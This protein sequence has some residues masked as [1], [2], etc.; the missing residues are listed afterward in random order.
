MPPMALRSTSVG[1]CTAHRLKPALRGLEGC[2]DRL[3]FG[4]EFTKLVSNSPA[5]DQLVVALGLFQWLYGHQTAEERQG[6]TSL[7]RNNLGF[8]RADA[9]LAGR[10]YHHALCVEKKISRVELQELIDLLLKYTGQLYDNCDEIGA[11]LGAYLKHDVTLLGDDGMSSEEDGSFVVP[12]HESDSESEPPPSKRPR[13]S[14]ATDHESDS[15]SELP[16]RRPRIRRPDPSHY[17][18]SDAT[19]GTEPDVEPGVEKRMTSNDLRMVGHF[20]E[21]AVADAIPTLRHMTGLPADRIH[22]LF[23]TFFHMRNATLT[24][25][26]RVHYKLDTPWR[27]RAGDTYRAAMTW[28]T[29]GLIGTHGGEYHLEVAG[30]A[31]PLPKYM[32]QCSF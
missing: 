30:D 25:A 7:V 2:S 17:A 29:D 15:E 16:S 9:E 24:P 22:E 27:S 4:S 18:E 26:K 1:Y 12:D 14:D 8:D 11:A 32:Y 6:M 21:H 23:Y 3:E 13:R 19:D 31:I 20:A 28:H 10:T 5:E